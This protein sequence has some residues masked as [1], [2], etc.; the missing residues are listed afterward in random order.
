MVLQV[1]Q[2][3]LPLRIG[4][5]SKR[6][7]S[8]FPLTFVIHAC[9]LLCK[10]RKVVSKV[11]HGVKLDIQTTYGKKRT[12][13]RTRSLID[14]WLEAT[15]LLSPYIYTSLYFKHTLAYGY[16]IVLTTTGW[17]VITTDI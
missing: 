5:E 13:A 16:K 3:S 10:E 2:S 1:S 12:L 9:N 14:G 15:W 11:V 17:D 6:Q 8:K 7:I 4:C